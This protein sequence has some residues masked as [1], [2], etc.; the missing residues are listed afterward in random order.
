MPRRKSNRP[1]PFETVMSE[2]EDGLP[3]DLDKHL[4]GCLAAYQAE[5]T[6]G[7]AVSLAFEALR[8]IARD[9]HINA[10]AGSFDPSQLDE[11]WI[12]SPRKTFPVPWIWIRVLS[13]A[14]EKYNSEGVPIGHAFGVE[15]GQGKPPSIDKLMQMLDERA[16]ARWVWW[17]VETLR[18]A[19]KETRIEDVVQ[20]AAEKFGKADVTIRRA[21]TKFGKLE[22]MRTTK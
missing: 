16:I 22:G 4:N 6:F 13:A 10:S 12:V 18:A 3:W 20:E 19:Q 15:G 11:E 8:G 17:R 21:W 9:I 5:P 7:A 2:A 1:R 14:W